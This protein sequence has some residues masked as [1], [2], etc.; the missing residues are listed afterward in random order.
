MLGFEQE[1]G[2]EQQKT[3]PEEVEMPWSMADV[4]SDGFGG[5]VV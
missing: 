3:D 1:I 4:W 2:L 5:D